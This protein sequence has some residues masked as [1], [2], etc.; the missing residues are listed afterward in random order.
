MSDNE[1]LRFYMKIN[2]FIILQIIFYT[3]CGTN[4]STT[5][6]QENNQQKMN[7]FT[8]YSK[9]AIETANN[10]NNA[11]KDTFK[12][13]MLDGTDFSEMFTYF[14][15]EYYAYKDEKDALI[16]L[17]EEIERTNKQNDIISPLSV[18][19]SSCTNETL[20]EIQRRNNCRQLAYEYDKYR[21]YSR[22]IPSFKKINDANKLLNTYS[23]DEVI[24]TFLKEEKSKAEQMLNTVESGLLFQLNKS[25]IKYIP[26][27]HPSYFDSLS[28]NEQTNL[29]KTISIAVKTYVRNLEQ[30]VKE[31]QSILNVFRQKL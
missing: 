9:I 19:L 16:Y 22:G 1:F 29:I 7:Y 17:N 30:Q 21:E 6:T 2:K 23:H 12:G 10:L 25:K 14:L 28:K 11:F 5:Y 15:T 3:I 18:T 24:V 8:H 13:T 26:G 31:I 27:T 20:T 4:N